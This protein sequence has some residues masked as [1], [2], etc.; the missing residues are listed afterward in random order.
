MSL[1][2]QEAAWS[3]AQALNNEFRAQAR[4]PRLIALPEYRREL[5]DWSIVVVAVDAAAAVVE[6]HGTRRQRSNGVDDS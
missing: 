3:I 2:T 5:C 6:S 4:L 1:L